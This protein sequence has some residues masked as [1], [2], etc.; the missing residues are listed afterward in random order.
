M[1]IAPM[2]IAENQIAP[3]AGEPEASQPPPPLPVDVAASNAGSKPSFGIPA[4]SLI[5]PASAGAFC[6]TLTIAQW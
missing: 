2:I 6:V 5:G 3:L 1:I 4:A